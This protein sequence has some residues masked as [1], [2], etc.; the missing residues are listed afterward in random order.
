MSN[1]VLTTEYI[2]NK[3]KSIFKKYDFIDK[4]YLFG[5]YAKNKATSDS[6]IDIVVKLNSNVGMK[7]YSLY[8]DFENALNKKVDVLTEN[9]IKAIMPKTYERDRVLIYEK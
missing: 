4:V 2:K 3:S 6:D 9:E 1:S 5:S 7:L 8:D